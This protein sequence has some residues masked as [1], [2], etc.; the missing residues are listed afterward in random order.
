MNEPDLD[1]HLDEQLRG[2][3][4]PPPAGQFAAM[5]AAA[6]ATGSARPR[7]LWPWLLAAAAL[8]VV[9]LLLYPSPRRGPEGHDGQQLGSLW[10]AAYHDAMAKGF[11]SNAASGGC[12]E[13]GFDLLQACQQRFSARLDVE[14]DGPVAVL[15]GYCGLPTGGCMTLLARTEGSPVCVYVVP[16]EHDPHVE[17]PAGSDLHLARRELDGL[18]LYAL[19]T[20]PAS[21]TLAEFLV[22]RP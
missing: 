10:A 17:L 21:T 16:R 18:V 22:P 1:R 19:S 2:S 7:P 13:P 3:F 20:S 5:A 14:R 4:A 15:G 11:S 12:C 9:G 8:L 6:T